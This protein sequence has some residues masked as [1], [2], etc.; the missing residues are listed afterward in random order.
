M[1]DALGYYDNIWEFD[2]TADWRRQ[3][4]VE[5]PDDERNLAA[6]EQLDQLK[7]TAQDVPEDVRRA[8]AECYANRGEHWHEM[9]RAVGFS[10]GYENA[11]SFCRSFL[12]A[13]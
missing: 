6:A 4:A 3:K 1:E 7:A 10:A 11:E 12:E 9:M 13:A 8:V 2:D 5:Y